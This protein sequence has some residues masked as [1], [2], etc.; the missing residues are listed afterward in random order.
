MGDTRI[1]P[2]GRLHLGNSAPGRLF[3]DI[4]ED[5]PGNDSRADDHSETDRDKRESKRS[6]GF[7]PKPT[8]KRLGRDLKGYCGQAPY[9]PVNERV[10]VRAKI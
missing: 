8:K 7:N 3:R 2:E 5:E 6:A 9:Q 1:S 10:K 4:G